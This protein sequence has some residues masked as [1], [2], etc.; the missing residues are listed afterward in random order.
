[1]SEAGQGAEA[2]P[3]QQEDLADAAKFSGDEAALL[4]LPDNPLPAGGKA[5]MFETSDHVRLRYALWDKSKGAQKGT[6]CLVHG[7][8]EYIEKYYETIEDFRARGFGVATFDWRGQGG[9]ER[10]ISN[11]KVG[12]VDSFEDYLTDLNDFHANILLPECT[13][14]FYLVGH[15]MGGLVSLMAA[16]RDPLMFDRVFLS[17]PMLAIP[18]LPLSTQGMA[19]FSEALSFVG[20][21]RVALARKA[22]RP[23]TA[24][25]FAGNPLTSDFGRY[26]RVVNAYAERPELIVG[27]PTMRWSAA[28]FRAMSRAEDTGLALKFR[29]PVLMLAA[30]RDEVVSTPAIERLGL[31]MRTGRHL[32]IAAARHELFQESDDIRAQVMAAFD[33]FIS[34][35]SA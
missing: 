31:S 22:D 30:A 26:M 12:Y 23:P 1:M 7:R 35:Q 4:D 28:A 27:S 25:R 6:I 13:P 21:G 24:E 20:L 3:V 34:E 33:A 11:P 17:A 29:V 32:V 14:P 18:G 9:S 5:A 15:S 10:L 16:A 2:Q 19:R 8:T